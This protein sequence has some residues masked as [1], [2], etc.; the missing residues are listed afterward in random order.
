MNTLKENHEF[1]GLK[2]SRPRIPCS[3]CTD[4]LVLCW[5][6]IRKNLYTQHIGTKGHHNAC[7]GGT[8]EGPLHYLAKQFLCNYLNQGGKITCKTWCQQCH[9]VTKDIFPSDQLEWNMEIVHDNI[10]FDIAGMKDNSVMA[11]IEIHNTHI[12]DNLVGRQDIPWI[13]VNC[14][15]VISSLDCSI[16]PASIKLKNLR[17]ADNC[18]LPYCIP[19]S[20]FGETLGYET[21]EG[22]GLKSRRWND[23]L[24]NAFIRIKQCIRCSRPWET[25][26]GR[27]YC[28]PCYDRVCFEEAELLGIVKEL[29]SQ[30]IDSDE[31]GE[32]LGYC[33][34]ED[35]YII[36][37]RK[38]ISIIL[39]G[40]YS[41]TEYWSLYSS[42]K[43][44]DP[45]RT[46][47]LWAIV[48]ERE[49]C[50]AC[51]NGYKVDRGRPYCMDC[52]KTMKRK[53]KMMLEPW[54][55]A[56]EKQIKYMNRFS[57]LS[58]IPSGRRK[59]SCYFCERN[60]PDYLDTKYGRYWEPNKIYVRTTTPWLNGERKRCCTICL[61]EQDTK[62]QIK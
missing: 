11:G 30:K 25:S 24:W 19:F 50:L 40:G 33:Y 27:C 10:R 17:H 28:V 9:R 20:A 44:F 43:S 48:V 12:T 35:E 31:I 56:S 26:K 6:K 47:A 22:W 46:A 53:G 32:E 29:R 16:A 36:K 5:G 15:S 55:G 2:Y 7:S 54:R 45:I 4:H 13:E 39:N 61:E 1:S 18:S 38:Y 59:S 57:W 34:R 58:D 51:C 21:A 41:K 62:R 52:F 42:K 23:D 37:Q 14:Y 8:G 49:K 60:V 3:E